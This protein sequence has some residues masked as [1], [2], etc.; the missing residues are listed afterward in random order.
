MVASTPSTGA[1]LR[2]A[3]G[4]A[5][6]A[7][8]ARCYEFS[9]VEIMMAGMAHDR[10]Y[11]ALT[12]QLRGLG[13]SAF[14]V[15]IV[16]QD[17]RSASV[18]TV[19]Q[20]IERLPRLK[21]ANMAGAA[22]YIRGP[23]DQDHDLVLVDDLDRFTPERMKAAGHAPAVVTETSPGNVQAWVR[24]GTP[25]SAVIRH[26]VSRDLARLYGGD[27]GAVDPH[28]SGRLA[29]FTNQK[30]QYKTAR[31]FPY[32]LLLNAPGRPASEAPQLIADATSADRARSRSVQMKTPLSDASADLITAWRDEYVARQGG[33]M[34]AID[35]S[36]A[37]QALAAGIDPEEIVSTL[38]IVA[39]R[40]GR[41]AENYARRT[42]AAV[43][44]DRQIPTP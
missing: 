20:I 7:P 36:T 15:S 4:F 6:K 37:H 29:G 8:L 17:H 16:N 14:E 19:T 1:R 42:V 27:P 44:Q 25:C 23:R 43:I 40:K 9:V 38:A 10:S 21:R 39:D 2:R 11:T 5:A 28:Q 18:W 26:E 13:L 35:W 32:V 33:D 24:L 30:P 34:S 3:S 12:R 31:G 22:I 41:H